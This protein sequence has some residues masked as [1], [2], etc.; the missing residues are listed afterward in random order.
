MDFD[1]R[2][3]DK[4]INLETAETKLLFYS[5][6]NKEYTDKFLKENGVVRVNNWIEIAKILL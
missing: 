3:D 4:L 5:Y 6:H 1:I 2:I